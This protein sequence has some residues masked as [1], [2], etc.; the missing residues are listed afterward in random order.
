MDELRVQPQDNLSL[1]TEM[2]LL[3][4]SQAAAFHLH[5]LASDMAAGEGGCSAHGMTEAICA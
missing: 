1:V 4:V 5:N 3:P 2:L